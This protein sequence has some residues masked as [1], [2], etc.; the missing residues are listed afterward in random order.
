MAF[1]RYGNFTYVNAIQSPYNTIF[2]LCYKY[3]IK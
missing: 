1:S 2:I 3:S